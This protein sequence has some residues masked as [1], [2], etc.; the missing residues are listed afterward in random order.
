MDNLLKIGA[1]QLTN[2]LTKN[3][4][5][6]KLTTSIFKQGERYVYQK[7]I[8][9]LKRKS[10]LSF[11]DVV[12]DIDYDLNELLNANEQPDGLY[13]LTATNISHNYESGMV[14]GW[15]LILKPHEVNNK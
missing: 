2:D 6:V 13:E 10:T 4:L 5:I 12:C 3:V 11:E 14:D 9:P 1:K 8:T 15:D 7:T